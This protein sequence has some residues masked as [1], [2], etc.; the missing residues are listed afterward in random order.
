MRSLLRL[1][2]RIVAILLT[3]AL[4]LLNLRLY[5][6]SAAD[7]GPNHIGADVVPQLR[8]IG[9]AL[10]QGSGQQMQAFFP[11]GFFFS[12]VLYGLAWAE[13]GM[14]LPATDALHTQALAE[15]RW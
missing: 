1:A 5:V 13:L 15:A 8:F 4:L 14:R 12:H 3:L 2:H 9:A 7:Y 6:P 10:R 11:E